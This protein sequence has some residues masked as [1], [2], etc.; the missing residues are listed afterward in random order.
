MVKN[1]T[2]YWYLQRDK[3]ERE[4][5]GRATQKSIPLNKNAG[6]WGITKVYT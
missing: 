1:V 6:V 2:N 5:G 4:R 3:V